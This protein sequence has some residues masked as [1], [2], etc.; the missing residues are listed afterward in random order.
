MNKVKFRVELVDNF[1]LIGN[2]LFDA[3]ANGGPTFTPYNYH[4]SNLLIEHNGGLLAHNINI[5]KNLA[6]MSDDNSAENLFATDITGGRVDSNYV[7]GGLAALSIDK[8]NQTMVGNNAISSQLPNYHFNQSSF[9][10]NTYQTTKP[11]ANYIVTKPNKYDINRGV[12]VVYNWALSP[13]ISVNPSTFTSLKPGDT[14]VLHTVQDYFSDTVRAVYTGGNIS[15]SMQNHLTVQKALGVTN[16]PTSTF[17]AYGVFVIEKVASGITRIG[18]KHET[19]EVK[20]FPN[21][22]NG[23]FEINNAESFDQYCVTNILGETIASGKLNER[24]IDLSL[25]NKGI[26]FLLL[27]KNSTEKIC[28]SKIIIK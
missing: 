16:T 22:S 28:V 11:S 4:S 27:T 14:Y 10:N 2:V 21:P 20:I 7:A 12:I 25:E 1:D 5:V 18:E 9:P 24:Y 26:Y 19:S 17:P 15:I 8:G 23:I 13:S 3:G 6:Y